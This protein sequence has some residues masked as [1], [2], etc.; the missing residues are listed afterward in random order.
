MPSMKQIVTILVIALVGIWLANNIGG[1][2][3]LVSKRVA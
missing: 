2:G 3:K 1:I